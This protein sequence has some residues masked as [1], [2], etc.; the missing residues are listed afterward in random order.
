MLP[1][2][3]GASFAL[4]KQALVIGD[5]LQIEP[6]WSIPESIDIGNLHAAEL[7]GKE[8]DAYERLCQSGR[9]AASG[10]V[11]QIAQ[12]LSRY[13]YDPEMARG[14]FLYEHHRCFDEIAGLPVTRRVIKANPHPQARTRRGKRLKNAAAGKGNRDGLPALGYLHVDGLC[15]KSSGGGSRHNLYEAQT[16]AAWLAEHRESL[17]AQYGKPLHCMWAS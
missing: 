16:I 9:S 2:V 1:E 10:S 4:G 6:I 8:E 3:A 17:Q 11:M 12:R 14:M 15:Q 13:H 5:Q 7:L